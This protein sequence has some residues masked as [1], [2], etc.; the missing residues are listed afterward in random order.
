[1][2]IGLSED[3]QLFRETTRQ[4]L[5]QHSPLTRVRGLI[6]DPE[7]LDRVMWRRGAELGWYSM[8]VPEQYGGGSISGAS[9]VDLT[10]VAAGREMQARLGRRERPCAWHMD[11]TEDDG[12]F[13]AARDGEDSASR[14]THLPS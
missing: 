9:L 13:A 1:M 12:R 10:I 6:E 14:N 2:E 3:Q 5:A 11:A 4:A 8:L 7:G